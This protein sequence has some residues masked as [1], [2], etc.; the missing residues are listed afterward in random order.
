MF[1]DFISYFTELIYSNSFLVESL[2]LAICS[3]MSAADNNNF[4]SS[5]PMLLVVVSCSVMS[6]S[7]RPHGLQPITLL[8]PW[9][10][11][12]KNTGVGCHRL[13]Q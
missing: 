2:E 1:N 10:F 7:L 5:L 13:L 12:G 6:D 11:P 3:I 9:D 4:T 8:R